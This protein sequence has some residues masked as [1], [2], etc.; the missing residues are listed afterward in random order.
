[1]IYKH[2][3]DRQLMEGPFSLFSEIIGLS[4]F[5]CYRLPHTNPNVSTN[6]HDV[7]VMLHEELSDDK[8]AAR[9]KKVIQYS[10]HTVYHSRPGHHEG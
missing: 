5:Y 2:Y 3:K 4:R 9:M 7:E 6:Q 1:M 8:R 10:Y